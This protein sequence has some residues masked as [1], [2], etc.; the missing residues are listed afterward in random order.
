MS[1]REYITEDT[2]EMLE[3]LI[4]KKKELKKLTRSQNKY[5]IITVTLIC[6]LFISVYL[7]ILNNSD[8]NILFA[9]SDF[10]SNIYNLLLLLSAVASHIG[11]LNYKKQVKKVKEGFEELRIETIEHLDNTWYITKHSHIINQISSYMEQHQINIRYK[12]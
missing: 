8:T 10:F 7:F 5:F 2:L 12:S 3:T 6:V 1:F 4:A 9:V 11:Q